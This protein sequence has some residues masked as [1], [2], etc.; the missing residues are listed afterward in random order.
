[1]TVNNAIVTRVLN[2]I[3]MPCRGPHMLTSLLST[4]S[5]PKSSHM[6]GLGNN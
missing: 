2:F 6:A 5:Y 4:D 1:M 3:W